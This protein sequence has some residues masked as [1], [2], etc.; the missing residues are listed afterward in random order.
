MYKLIL[1]LLFLIPF[2]SFADPFY[3][4]S[5]EKENST[6]T[7]SNIAKKRVK[8]TACEMPEGANELNLPVE[9]EDLK[10]IGVFKNKDKFKALFVDKNNQIFDFIQNDFL[11]DKSIQIS[12]INTKLVKYIN[13]DLTE[14][15]QSPYQIT[16][17][18]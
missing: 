12:E 14:D 11:K 7:K 9:F 8:T 2:K 15:C 6:Q 10:L 4:D 18:L 13:W 17:K 16:L 1:F 3:G 5:T